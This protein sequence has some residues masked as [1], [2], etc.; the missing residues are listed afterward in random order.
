[1]ND[2]LDHSWPY[3]PAPQNMD[4][5]TRDAECGGNQ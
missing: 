3:L 4:Q 2:D 5:H 1:M